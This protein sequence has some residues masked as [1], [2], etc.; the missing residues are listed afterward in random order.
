MSNEGVSRRDMLGLAAA[1]IAAEAPLMASTGAG[2]AAVAGASATAAAA[3][4]APTAAAAPVP[5]DRGFIRLQEGLVHYRFAGR[6]HLGRRG[7]PLPVYFAHAGPGSGRVYEPYLQAFGASRFAFAPDMLG[8]GDSAP[9][10]GEVLEIGY[11]V[12]C[13]LRLADQLGLERFDFCGSHTGAQ[14]GCQLAVEHPGRIRRL[15]LDGIPL[16]PADLKQRML[17]NYAPKIEP[18]DYGT[19]LVWAWNFVRDQQLYFPWFERTGARRLSNPVP[20]A[21]QLQASVA[22]VVKA[23]RTYHIAYR[24]AFRQDLHAL[25]PKVRCPV[26]LTTSQRDPLTAWFDD[27]LRL[28]PA[29]SP[30]A[31]FTPATTMAERLAAIA[32]FLDA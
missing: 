29:G 3:K 26:F 31:I 16:F 27:A 21:A 6:E 23:L 22:D 25:L 7:A 18:D 4:P 13:A 8:N 11:Y 12:D 14:I 10:A 9:P 20:P 24:A 19:H 30:H 1:S 28:A 32:G 15:V 5:V 17:E 2:V